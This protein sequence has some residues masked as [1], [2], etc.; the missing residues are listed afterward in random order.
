MS[1]PYNPFPLIFTCRDEPVKLA[2][3][4][5][6]GLGDRPKAEKIPS[7]LIEKQR[8]D[9]AF[10]YR[11]DPDNW[12]IVETVRNTLHLL[13]AGLNPD[14]KVIENA[15]EF[16]LRKQRPDGG[17]SENKAFQIP[18]DQVEMSNRQ[19]ITWV[20]ADT[21]ELLHQVDKG[22]EREC[23]KAIKWLKKYAK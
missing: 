20:T 3:L 13:K 10:P 19:P 12:G 4:K 23:K 16:I 21:V 9:G 2:C 1:L 11:T 22:K 6:F 14:D 18:E 8:S 17:W 7:K 15:V 5:F